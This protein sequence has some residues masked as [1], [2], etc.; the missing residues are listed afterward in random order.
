MRRIVLFCLFVVLAARGYSQ[1]VAQTTA[2]APSTLPPVRIDFNGYG[3][4]FSNGIGWWRGFNTT[5][6]LRKSK[7]FIPAFTFDQ[8]QSDSGTQRYVSFFSYA[9]WTSNFFTTQ[10]I[11]G[12]PVLPGSPL[13]FPRFRA[14]FKPWWKIP[15]S[16]RLVAGL[17]FTRFEIS[18]P[19]RGTIINPGLLYY[20]GSWVFDWEAFANQSEP[21]SLWSGSGLFTVQQGH[22]GKHWVGGS[23][24]AGKQVYRELSTVPLD[25]RYSSTSV[26]VFYRRWITRNIGVTATGGYL[27]AWKTYHRATA[28]AGFFFEF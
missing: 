4:D 15:P 1:T 24:G 27:D 2:T 5:I 23:V 17:G 9:N 25:I 12:V 26:D 16:R 19:L 11:A 28:S 18:G 3:E 10:A 22:E 8:R 14:D 20:R 6:W 13:L 7:K 21:G